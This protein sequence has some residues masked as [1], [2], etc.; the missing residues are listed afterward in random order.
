[1]TTQDTISSKKVSTFFCFLLVE[2]AFFSYYAALGN[3]RNGTIL[4]KLENL[5]P[6]NDMRVI[7][8]S[9]GVHSFKRRTQIRPVHCRF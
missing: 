7:N 8:S 3:L 2:N 4:Q 1:M 6:V 9:P 5:T